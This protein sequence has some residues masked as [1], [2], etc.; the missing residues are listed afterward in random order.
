[1]TDVKSALINKQIVWIVLLVSVVFIA[2]GAVQITFQN[3]MQ[4][5][6]DSSAKNY[7]KIQQSQTILNET[8]G[9]ETRLVQSI[10]LLLTERTALINTIKNNTFNILSTLNHTLSE[11]GNQTALLIKGLEQTGNASAQAAAIKKIEGN[12][13]ALDRIERALNITTNKLS[14]STGEIS[15]LVGEPIIINP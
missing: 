10:N 2:L 8:I 6:I 9:N 13:D 7:E 5:A 1:M 11:H 3:Q 15:S 14:N 12:V 4:T